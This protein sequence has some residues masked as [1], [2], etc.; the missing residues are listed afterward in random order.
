MSRDY[1]NSFNTL[2]IIPDTIKAEHLAAV[3]V[4]L[5][6]QSKLLNRDKSDWTSILDRPE[7]KR[8]KATDDTRKGFWN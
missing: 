8:V 1:G 3:R 4:Q 7:T 6:S 5:L 2:R